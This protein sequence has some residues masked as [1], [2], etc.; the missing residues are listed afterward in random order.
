MIRIVAG[1]YR[2]LCINQPNSDKVRP[3]QDRVREA[4]FSALGDIENRNTLDL[5]AGSGAL[6]FEALSRGASKVTFVD[7][8]KLCV[9]AIKDSSIKIHCENDV[10]IY[11]NDYKSALGKLS[12]CK[13]GLVLLDPPYKMNINKEIVEYMVDNDML[14]GDAIVVAEQESDIEEIDGFALK[15]YKY[16]YKQVGIYRRVK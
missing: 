12:S 11:L 2:R 6:G 5:F 9:Q 3:T 1:K 13:Y 10:V 16:S 7:C 15:R 14:E 4:M 8:L